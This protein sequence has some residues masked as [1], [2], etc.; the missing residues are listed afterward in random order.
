[1]CHCHVD[2]GFLG[3][4]SCKSCFVTLNY[5]NLQ[6]YWVFRNLW[7]P[8]RELKIMEK[9]HINI[10]LCL[11]LWDIMNFLFQL[12]LQKMQRNDHLAFEDKPARVLSFIWLLSPSFLVFLEFVASLAL[13]RSISAFSID[14]ACT[15]D[16]KCPHKWKSNGFKS[17]YF[18]APRLTHL[19]AKYWFKNCLATRLNRGAYEL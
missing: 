2:S 6:L 12:L 18:Y 10:C 16:S 3:I 9:S 8:P 17:I 4:F 7:D 11:R 14:V 13:F 1:M 15:I 19:F 5:V